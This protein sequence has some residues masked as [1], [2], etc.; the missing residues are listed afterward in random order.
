M[1]DNGEIS[2]Y[3][4]ESALGRWSVAMCPVHPALRGC[5]AQIWLGEGQVAYQ[6]DR[7]LPRAQSY[8]LINLG[9]PQYRILTGDPETR[10]VFDDVWFSG[11][12]ESPIDT[13]APHGSVLLG[14][15][16]HASG[17]GH[18]LSIP[19]VDLANRTGPLVD[20]IGTLASELRQRLLQTPGTHAR[21]RLVEAWLLKT[22]T[23]G[24]SI[25]PL[26]HWATRRLADS[27]GQLRTAALAREAGV[28]RKHLSGLFSAQ[29]GLAPKALARVHRFHHLLDRLSPGS[30]PDWSHLALDCGY[31]DQSHLIHDFR[32][33]SGMSPAEFA[34]H[35]MPDA[36]SVV[37]R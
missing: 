7:I 8:L 14:V 3:R 29:V 28:S 24:R 23:S 25:H 2:I 1:N 32:Q 9:P 37:L 33:Y 26:V 11:L 30:A 4:H 12:S 18:W 31:Y 15:A 10:E 20:V 19:Q 34:R 22:C 13:E 17:A 36:R 6:R 5:V 16:F 35:S 21:L 27:G